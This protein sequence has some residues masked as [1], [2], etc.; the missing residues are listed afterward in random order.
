M[1]KPVYEVLRELR[2]EK[3][4]SIE[5]TAAVLEIP[6]KE[7]ISIEYGNRLILS[8]QLKALLDYYGISASD[9]T[10]RL[11]SDND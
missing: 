8:K 1:R 9:F 5:D 6:A 11:K 10:K 4:A 7:L 2:K 3:G